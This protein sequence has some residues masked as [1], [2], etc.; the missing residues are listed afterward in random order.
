M[1]KEITFDEIEVETKRSIQEGFKGKAIVAYIDL[2]GFKDE[3]VNNWNTKK[4]KKD[5]LHRLMS[6]KAFL[7]LAAKRA[8]THDFEDYSGKVV[9]KIPYPTI[10][11]FSDSFIFILPIENEDP[12]YKLGCI[13]AVTGSIIELWRKSMDEGFTIRG[14]VDYGEIYHNKLDLIGPS[15]ITTYL[16]ESKIAVTSRVIYSSAANKIVADNLP[17]AKKIFR[18]YFKRYFIADIDKLLII[19]PLVVFGGY[20]NPKLLKRTIKQ[21]KKMK[22]RVTKPLIKSKYDTLISRLNSRKK[23]MYNIKIF[24]AY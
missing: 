15:L 22:A 6:I 13:L 9:L 3:I 17:S 12:T 10:I 14:A 8:V 16:N 5:P 23:K 2:L 18:D 20:N 24:K 21:L 4:K 19:N 1:K 11:T 7:D